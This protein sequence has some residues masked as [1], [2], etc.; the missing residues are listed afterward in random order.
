MAPTPHPERDRLLALKVATA[1]LRRALERAIER[2][3]ALDTEVQKQI[4]EIECAHE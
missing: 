1:N 3:H 2:A 4:R